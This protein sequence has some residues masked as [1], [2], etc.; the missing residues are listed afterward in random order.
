MERLVE[1][2]SWHLVKSLDHRQQPPHANMPWIPPRILFRIIEPKLLTL[3]NQNFIHNCPSAPTS[4]ITSIGHGQ[5]ELINNAINVQ[6][7]IYAMY[8]TKT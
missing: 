2:N 3:P 4:P 7:L 5:I 1:V 8:G 6:Q